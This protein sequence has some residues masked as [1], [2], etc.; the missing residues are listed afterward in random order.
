MTGPDA[1]HAA[2]A[3]EMACD[4]LLSF[5]K[6]FHKNKKKLEDIGLRVHL[7]RNT[8]SLPGEYRQSAFELSPGPAAS[9][10]S[11]ISK[12]KGASR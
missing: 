12:G 6:V 11:D 10:R 5:D 2:S 3:L 8:Q 1:I 7:P 9:T 4:E